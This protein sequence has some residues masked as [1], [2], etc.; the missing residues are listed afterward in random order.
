[1][2]GKHVSKRKK[3][4]QNPLKKRQTL[5]VKTLDVASYL[6]ARLMRRAETSAPFTPLHFELGNSSVYFPFLNSD[7]DASPFPR[8]IKCGRGEKK[9]GEGKKKKRK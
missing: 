3:S 9:Q 1:M 2:A 8:Q 5:S 7:G 4:R 6:F